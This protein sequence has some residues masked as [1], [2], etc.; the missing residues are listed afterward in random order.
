ML[1]IFLIEM[2]DSKDNLIFK[3]PG[4]MDPWT[5]DPMLF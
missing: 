3:I 5:Q 1:F 4:G 2:W